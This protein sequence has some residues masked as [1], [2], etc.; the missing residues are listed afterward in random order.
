VEKENRTGRGE[1]RKEGL[2]GETGE[3]EWG[4]NWKREERKTRRRE[5][6]SR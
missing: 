4:W 5:D 3:V 6:E 1:K 2:E